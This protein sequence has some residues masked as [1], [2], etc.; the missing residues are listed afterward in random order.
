MPSWQKG[1]MRDLGTRGPASIAM[2]INDRGQ[3]IGGTGT[4]DEQHAF[5]WQNGRTTDLGLLSPKSWWSSAAAI[6]EDDQRGP[7][8]WTRRAS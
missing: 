4:S 3:V 6:N 2:A 7:C 8:C 5:V 1:K